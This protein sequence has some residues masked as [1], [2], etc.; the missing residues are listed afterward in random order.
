MPWDSSSTSNDSRRAASSSITC[1]TGS[2]I[3]STRKSYT[4]RPI[5]PFLVIGSS[6]ALMYLKMLTEK[7][8]LHV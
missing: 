4:V 5:L 3:L 6:L 1:T 2:R 8:P 7:L